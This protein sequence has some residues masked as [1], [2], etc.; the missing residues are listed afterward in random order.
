MVNIYILFKGH[1]LMQRMPQSY[2]YEINDNYF[3]CDIYHFLVYLLKDGGD[4]CLKANDNFI[5]LVISLKLGK[6]PSKLSMTNALLMGLYA[7]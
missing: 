1:S 2:L 5:P 7:I 3:H 4:K 6:C